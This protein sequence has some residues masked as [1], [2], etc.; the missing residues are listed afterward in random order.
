VAVQRSF[1]PSTRVPTPFAGLVGSSD[2]FRA[3]LEDVKT[4]AE[5]DCTVLVQG[6]TGTGKEGIA[7]AIPD[8]SWRRQQRF[9]V[10]N[11]AA[12]PTSL[13]EAELFMT[14]GL[15]GPSL[16]SG[17]FSCRPGHAFL[18]EIGELPLN[19]SPR[20]RDL[21]PIDRIGNHSRRSTSDRGATNQDLLRWWG[22]PLSRHLL[23]IECVCNHAAAL[24]RRGG[25]IRLLADHKSH[26]RSP[27]RKAIPAIP[28]E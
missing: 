27:S 21:A 22:T 16:E 24:A 1:A 23:P 4:V 28:D 9:V 11:C 13:L 26:I 25:D 6:E 12:I 17:R 14:G 20:L 3:A 2:K 8:L 10:V 5:T 15:H 7:Q 18:D 19:C